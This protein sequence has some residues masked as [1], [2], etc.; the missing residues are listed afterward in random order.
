MEAS[1]TASYAPTAHQH[2]ANKT[3]ADVRIKR[4]SEGYLCETHPTRRMKIPGQAADYKIGKLYGKTLVS[5]AVKEKVLYETCPDC[6]EDRKMA[7]AAPPTPPP[8]G[9]GG[10]AASPPPTPYSTITS[11]VS[12]WLRQLSLKPADHEAVGAYLCDEVGLTDDIGEL[13]G[14]TEFI[15]AAS[16]LL[17]GVK[18]KKFLEL[19]EGLSAEGEKGEIAAPAIVDA[20]AGGAIGADVLWE[21]VKDKAGVDKDKNVAKLDDNFLLAF[22][23]VF[24]LQAAPSLQT[25]TQLVDINRNGVV[26]SAEFEEFYDGWTADGRTVEKYIEG[27]LEGRER[28]ASKARRDQELEEKETEIKTLASQLE[29]K[30]SAGVAAAAADAEKER[31]EAAAAAAKAEREKLVL[32]ERLAAA[33]SARAAEAAAADARAAAAEA[34]LAREKKLL[35]A[36]RARLEAERERVAQAADDAK[37]DGEKKAAEEAAARKA[38]EEEAARKAAAEGE[39][40]RTEDAAA[41][42]HEK[43]DAGVL[44]IAPESASF[45]LSRNDSSATKFLI[46]SCT[47]TKS[48]YEE[49]KALGASGMAE[50]LTAH[51][52]KVK[53]H[54]NKTITSTYTFDAAAEAKRLA[55]EKRRQAEADAEKGRGGGG[56]KKLEEMGGSD[57]LVDAAREGDAEKVREL[58]AAGAGV[59]YTKEGDQGRT[60]LY[61]A[62]CYGHREAVQALIDAGADVD[63]GCTDDGWT[64][65]I[66]AAYDGHLEI[67]KALVGAKANVNKP[68]NNGDTP[69]KW[70]TRNRKTAVAEYLKSVGGHE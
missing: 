24:K 57:A 32:E 28:A 68:M 62:A 51:W 36:E 61:R 1:L 30:E 31:M 53:E 26:T 46:K 35:E 29:R 37:R 63:K 55:D 38:A 20:G 49:T 3:D 27:T 11:E 6:E 22:K 54:K 47:V 4:I 7:R 48:F 10:F 34:E 12:N 64:P 65:L 42:G 23:K 56:G 67:V 33:E 41:D 13:A 66:T 14:E 21:R 59:N 43:R 58:L 45:V 44:T 69:L 50:T 9:M 16:K 39:A 19:A 15:Q 8:G 2:D 25:M 70:A 5:A 40:K 17:K 52:K 60:P 18:Q